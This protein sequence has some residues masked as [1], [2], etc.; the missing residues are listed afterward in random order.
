MCN[1]VKFIPWVKYYILQQFKEEFHSNSRLLP[2][3]ENQAQPTPNHYPLTNLTCSSFIK[4]LIYYNEPALHSK[5]GAQNNTNP[6]PANHVSGRSDTN[7]LR[8]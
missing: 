6:K 1:I 2:P 8:M 5:S 3:N 7:S 4:K